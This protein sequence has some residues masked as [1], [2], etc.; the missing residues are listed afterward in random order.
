M[1]LFISILNNKIEGYAT[2]SKIKNVEISVDYGKTW[3]KTNI[4][5]PKEWLFVLWEIS[6]DIKDIKEIWCRAESYDGIMDTEVSEGWN[7]RGICNDSIY[8]KYM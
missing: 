7:I 6:Y 2:S 4:I 3:I 1:S 5:S 8:K